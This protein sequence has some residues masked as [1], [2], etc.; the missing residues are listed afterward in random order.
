MLVWPSDV[1][2]IE[3]MPAMVENCFSSG[4]ATEEAIV[5]G[6]APGRRRVHLDGRESRRSADRSPAAGDTRRCRR[7]GSPIMTSVVMIGRLM[8]SSGMLTARLLPFRLRYRWS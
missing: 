7:R 4:V 6:L 5:S 1:E 3:S 2:V 8:K